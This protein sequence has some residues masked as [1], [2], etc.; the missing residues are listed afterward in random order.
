LAHCWALRNQARTPYP[1]MGGGSVWF[2]ASFAPAGPV[3]LV[4]GVGGLGFCDVNSG[5]EHLAADPT[6]WVCRN[7]DDP[8]GVVS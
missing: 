4:W 2:F 8:V 3:G 6:R 1:V 7:C 5:R